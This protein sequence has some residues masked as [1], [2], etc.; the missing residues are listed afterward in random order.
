MNKKPTGLYCLGQ[1]F[2]IWYL[3]LKKDSIPDFAEP[4]KA[5]KYQEYCVFHGFPWD[6][7]ILPLLAEQGIP[8]TVYQEHQLAEDICPSDPDVDNLSHHRR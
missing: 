1:H 4:C 2:A 8:I 3:T 5:C 7:L 6:N